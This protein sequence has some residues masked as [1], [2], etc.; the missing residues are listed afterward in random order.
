LADTCMAGLEGDALAVLRHLLQ[1]GA[2]P[3]MILGALVGRVR[4]VARVFQAPSAAAAQAGMAPWLADKVRRDANQ[5]SE[6]GLARAI[7]A[8]AETD[9]AVKGGSRDPVFALESMVRI[10]CQRGLI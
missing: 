8:L 3:V 2:D 6:P 4:Q 1:T 5:W 10:I 9:S 7:T